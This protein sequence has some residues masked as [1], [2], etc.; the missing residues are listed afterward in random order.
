MR[1][2]AA[3]AANDTNVSV[4]REEI[5][6]E[7]NQLTSEINRIGNTTEFNT[8]SLLKGKN[9][10]V[11]ES[12]ATVG[13]ITE[14][15]AG[16]PAGATTALTTISSSVVS[17][18]STASVQ[19]STSEVTGKVSD[20]AETAQSVKGVKATS[21]STNGITFEAAANGIALNGKTITINQSVTDGTTS[22]LVET[23]N[24]DFEF[25]IGRTADGQSLANNRGE[26][27]NELLA[28]IKAE[29]GN[30]ITVK[31]PE[32]TDASLTTIPP[33]GAAGTVST[34]GG[35]VTEALGAYTISITDQIKEAGDTITIGDQTFTAVLGA[36]DVTKGQ[37]TI[38]SASALATAAVQ[39][40]NLKLAIDANATLTDRFAPTEAAGVITLTEKAGKATGVALSNAVV[41][42]SGVND[43]LTVTNAGGKN[44]GQVTI[45][46]AATNKATATLNIGGN[47]LKLSG[48]ATDSTLNGL[49]ITFGSDSNLA[50]AATFDAATNTVTVTSDWDATADTFDNIVTAING[51]IPGATKL[52]LLAGDTDYTGTVAS[53]ANAGTTTLSGGI[54]AG[55]VDKL[56]VELNQATGGLT[57]H[58]ANATASKNTAAKIQEAVQSFGLTGGTDYAKF[59]FTAE[60][61][62]DTNTL[63]NSITKQNGTFV[64]GIEEVKGQYTFDVSKAFAAGDIV[65]IAG[66]KFTAVAEK[67]DVTKGQFNAVAGDINGQVAGLADAV[68]LNSALKDKYTV[69]I[70]GSTITLTENTATG[71]DLKASDLAVKATGT[72]GEYAVDSEELLAS[73]SKFIVDGEEILVTNKNQHVGYDNGTAVKVTETQADQSKA[74]AEAINKNANLKGKYEASVNDKGQLVLKQTDTNASA[75]PPAVSTKNSSEGDFQATFQIGANSGQSMTITVG[76]MRSEALGISGDGSV[77]TVKANN[78]SVASYTQVANVNSGSDNKNVEFALD[79]TTSEKASAALSVIND[80]IEKVSAQRS[81]LGAFQNRLEHT[82]NNLGTSSENLVASESRIRDV[83]MAKEMMEFTKN[84]ILSQAAQAML[85]QANQQPQGVLQLLR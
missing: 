3:Q 59:T 50:T 18:A 66:Q 7:I 26:L 49:K 68:S 38:G 74:L 67:A 83:D 53:L 37:F 82:I 57:I 28:A 11:V 80:A 85:A 22:S 72:Q 9:V 78:G 19:G 46:Q 16:V 58:L 81:Q 79:V 42:G 24:G 73:G 77:G 40:A 75:T 34:L 15:V 29:G 63:G 41:S 8:Q 70:S 27:Y 21:I 10:P 55:D 14:G 5:Q 48:D 71:K 36:A 47:I 62:W 31:L 54:G 44:L 23:G 84:N 61:N 39:T 33:V 51:A 12:A 25:T 52:E 60:G 56:T 76:D 65:E 30:K 43:K 35:G 2:L 45:Q 13:T 17:K 6:K 69:T 1:E 64:G 32:N 4:D 20:V